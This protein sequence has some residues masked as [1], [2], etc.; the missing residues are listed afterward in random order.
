M[1]RKK[2]AQEELAAEMKIEK[3][4]IRDE[5]RYFCGRLLIICINIK[6]YL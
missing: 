4:R 1:A 5:V 3:K 6:Y 2:R